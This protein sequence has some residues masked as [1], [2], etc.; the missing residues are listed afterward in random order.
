MTAFDYVNLSGRPPGRLVRYGGIVLPGIARV[1]AQVEPYAAAW[2][3]D[4]LAALS[5]DDRPLWVALG[6]SL[7]LGIGAP[8]HDRGWVGRLRTRLGYRVV[9][10]GVSGATTGDVLDRQVPVLDELEPDLVT[11]MI[12]SNDLL[13]AANRRLL[14][15]RFARIL[16]RLPAGAVVTTLPNPRRAAVGANAVL[17]RVAAER[18]LVVAELRDPR[19]ASWRGRLAD[20]HFHPNEAGYAAMAEVIGSVLP[21]P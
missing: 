18:G 20:D 2:Q 7:T 13:R 11:L 12:G 14:V 15:A 17:R 1:Q 3:R 10:L 5:V 8:A 6:D 19:L 21:T 9:N 4:N 16:G